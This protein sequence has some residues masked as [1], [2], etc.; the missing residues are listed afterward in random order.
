MLVLRDREG[1]VSGPEQHREDALLRYGAPHH[2]D[3]GSRRMRSKVL[4]WSQHYNAMYSGCLW[5]TM[6][7]RDASPAAGRGTAKSIGGLV[8][9]W[10]YEKDRPSYDFEQTAGIRVAALRGETPRAVRQV[11]CAG[12]RRQVR[13]QTCHR[14]VQDACSWRDSRDGADQTVVALVCGLGRDRPTD[15]S[16]ARRFD[17]YG[18][19]GCCFRDTMGMTPVARQT[20]MRSG[21]GVALTNA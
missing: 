7:R 6:E 2:C 3:A 14:P 9:F 18:G 1:G 13:V 16:A 4:D 19:G 15:E 11:R 21:C 20:P 12:R 8:A 5:D 17:R 10:T